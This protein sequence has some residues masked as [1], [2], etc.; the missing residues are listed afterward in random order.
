MFFLVSR[1]KWEPDLW[2][3]FSALPNPRNPSC[4]QRHSPQSRRLLTAWV[5]SGAS[6]GREALRAREWSGQEGRWAFCVHSSSWRHPGSSTGSFSWEGWWKQFSLLC[7]FK[8][9]EYDYSI[10]LLILT[11]ALLLKYAILFPTDI[12]HLERVYNEGLLRKHCKAVRRDNIFLLLWNS[13]GGLSQAVSLA[14]NA[15]CFLVCSENCG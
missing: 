7:C 12:T 13:S 2:S 15:R 6:S 4:I 9:E 8:R 14:L 3:C 10:L 11:L 1:S 5:A